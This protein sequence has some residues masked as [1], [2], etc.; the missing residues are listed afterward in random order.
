MFGLLSS[1]DRRSLSL[2]A[3]SSRYSALP[4]VPSPE[5]QSL[6][7]KVS[8]IALLNLQPHDLEICAC[9]ECI[10]G[11][12]LNRK[13]R[14]ALDLSKHSSY[15]A[16]FDPSRALPDPNPSVLRIDHDALEKP[17]SKSPVVDRSSYGG[18]YS[19]EEPYEKPERKRPEDELR[20]EGPVKGLSAYGEQYPAFRNNASPYV[21][22]RPPRSSPPR[23]PCPTPCA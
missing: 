6:A 19:K 8:R 13:H 3:R 7:Q 20:F 4:A 1:P 11:R 9:E 18:S 23:C 17:R 10:Y 2:A 15:R 21:L 14:I 22:H 16:H 5:E 12:Q